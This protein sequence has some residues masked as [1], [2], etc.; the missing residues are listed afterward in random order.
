M[1]VLLHTER[2]IHAAPDAVYAESGRV[3]PWQ[4]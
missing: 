3:V 4:P 2:I 1:N